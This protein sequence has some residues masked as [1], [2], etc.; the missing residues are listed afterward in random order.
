MQL[1]FAPRKARV[2]GRVVVNGVEVK[3]EEG[4]ELYDLVDVE[5]GQHHV[6]RFPAHALANGRAAEANEGRG[7]GVDGLEVVG[8][9][10]NGRPPL[11]GWA[12]EH[13]N[14]SPRLW[15]R[16]ERRSAKRRSACRAELRSQMRNRLELRKC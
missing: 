3:C 2:E 16:S 11:G 7:E 9:A 15:M 8:S 4:A 6:Q 10:G 12:P 1:T 5:D 14:A 13:S